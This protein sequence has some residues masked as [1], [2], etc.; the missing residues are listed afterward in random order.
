MVAPV[1][2]EEFTD[3]V[4]VEDT[5]DLMP[6]E[7]SDKPKPSSRPR[8]EDL[9]AELISA[10]ATS[11][12]GQVRECSH[13]ARCGPVNGNLGCHR[14]GGSCCSSSGWCG[15]SSAHCDN[16]QTEYSCNCEGW[17]TLAGGVSTYANGKCEP[18]NGVTCPAGQK[19]KTVTGHQFC[20][21][22]GCTATQCCETHVTD[23]RQ[24]DG[25]TSEEKRQRQ[26][27]RTDGRCGPL[28]GH[29]KCN[30]GTSRW[31]ALY[32]N[33][34]TGQCGNTPTDRDAQRSDKY[35]AGDCMTTDMPVKCYQM[36]HPSVKWEQ[37]EQAGAFYYTG[38]SQSQYR[39]KPV[40]LLSFGKMN[41]RKV[42]YMCGDCSEVSCCPNTQGQNDQTWTTTTDANTCHV[43]DN[44]GFRKCKAADTNIAM[45]ELSYKSEEQ[46]IPTYMGSANI[47]EKCGD[48]RPP[49]PPDCT[50]TARWTGC[51]GM[52]QKY[53]KANIC[54][55]GFVGCPCDCPWMGRL[56]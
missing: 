41:E 25:C 46:C 9:P 48:A 6:S 47:Q 34:E 17:P 32:C 8:E 1:P 14:A 3:T 54:T 55:E 21:P 49:P 38:I 53:G 28:F 39:F 29:S 35:D 19:K 11:R 18:C 16:A 13:N 5:T 26:C 4:P 36:Q 33:E 30:P 43:R 20:P 31:S 7:D 12:V 40:C 50:N 42:R 10:I 2:E 27:S 37:G 24:C 56:T 45:R 52:I 23:S 15:S 51:K 22:T 44:H